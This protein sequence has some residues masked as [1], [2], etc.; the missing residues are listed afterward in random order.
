[1]L[2]A[3]AQKVLELTDIEKLEFYRLVGEGYKAMKDGRTSTIDEVKEKLKKM[4]EDR[5]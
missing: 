2:V 3:N 5:G 1:M 4:R